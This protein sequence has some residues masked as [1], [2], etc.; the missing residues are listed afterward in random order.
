M[1]LKCTKKEL[2]W[3]SLKIGDCKTQDITFKNKS[4]TNKIKVI[5]TV[6][7]EGFRVCLIIKKNGVIEFRKHS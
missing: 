5:A 3:G 6:I 1:F 7:G 4:S 2:S